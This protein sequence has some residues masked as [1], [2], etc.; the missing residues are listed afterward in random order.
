MIQWARKLGINKTT[1]RLRLKRG[2]TTEMALFTPAI[3]GQN[4]ATIM[5]LRVQY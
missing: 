4:G 1:L 5:A 3:R 2:W